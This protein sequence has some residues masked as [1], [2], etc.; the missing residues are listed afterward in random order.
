MRK[1]KNTSLLTDDNS[2]DSEYQQVKIVK[3][4]FDLSNFHLPTITIA[5][6]VVFCVWITWSAAQERSNIEAQINQLGD[7]L[8]VIAG[9][10]V[11]LQ[12]QTSLNTKNISTSLN[13]LS[14]LSKIDSEL[15][16]KKIPE[17]EGESKKTEDS[18]RTV[19]TWSSTD[20]MLWCLRT[21]ILNPGWKCYIQKEIPEGA[22]H[23][24]LP[25]DKPKP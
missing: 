22:T 1:V 16:E 20:H 15:L 25:T 7:R 2:S 9:D 13:D 17:L 3:D 6:I 21:Q 24:L 14:Q 19:E 23:E 11:K 4:K 8:T 18:I 12:E 5:S 10:M